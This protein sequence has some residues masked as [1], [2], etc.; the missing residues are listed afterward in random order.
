M[1]IRK[2]ARIQSP[3][4]SP[5]QIVPNS[6]ATDVCELNRSLWEV[7]SL[8]TLQSEYTFQ[9]KG[10]D[11]YTCDSVSREPVNAPNSNIGYEEEDEYA[12]FEEEEEIRPR[13]KKRG[14]K[15]SEEVK[16]E[17]GYIRCGKID[18]KGWQCK[19]EAKQGEQLCEHHMIQLQSYQYKYNYSSR[20]STQGKPSKTVVAANRKRNKGRVSSTSPADFYFYAGFGPSWRK[21]RRGDEN[22]DQLKL[23]DMEIVEDDIEQ[24]GSS[25]VVQLNDAYCDDNHDDFIYDFDS[26]DDEE[27]ETNGKKRIRKPIKARSLKSLL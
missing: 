3:P 10:E 8:T 6:P 16:R 24:V 11:E 25:S 20:K 12:I 13:V 27:E 15:K 19:N 7:I 18:G 14:R 23:E 22:S 9:V 26:D 5:P 1:R 2:Q 21:K 4:I 17:P